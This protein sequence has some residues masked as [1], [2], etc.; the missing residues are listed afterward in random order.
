[1]RCSISEFLWI[2]YC[3]SESSWC[4]VVDLTVFGCQMSSGKLTEFETIKWQRLFQ[5][6]KNKWLCSLVS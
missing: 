5:F 6:D 3:G 4:G 2:N 1:M